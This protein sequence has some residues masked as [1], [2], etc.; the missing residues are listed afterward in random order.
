MSEAPS[1][2]S[3]AGEPGMPRSLRSR[4]WE[5][6]IGAIVVIALASIF[7][8]GAGDRVAVGSTG[9]QL[10]PLCMSRTVF[11]VSC[12]GCGLTR[13]FVHL[14]HGEVQSSL[15]V[16]RV[17]WLLALAV[18]AQIPYRIVALRTANGLPLGE[19]I[20]RYFGYVLIAA[21]VV[22]WLFP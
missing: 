13:S 21:L 6:L 18:V 17:G 8:V 22:N 2:P 20:P 7:T 15:Q 19:R 1:A 14:A 9:I 3:D 11:G 5:M 12:P 4:H 10:P 16:H